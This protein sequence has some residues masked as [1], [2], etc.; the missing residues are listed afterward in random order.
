MFDNLKQV[1]D[2]NKRLT[3]HKRGMMYWKPLQAR[4]TI[5]TVHSSEP[6]RHVR[7][8]GVDFYTFLICVTEAGFN[9]QS[10]QC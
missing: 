9:I 6:T 2:W 4:S 10:V 8:L 1:E 7:C 5:T 3:E